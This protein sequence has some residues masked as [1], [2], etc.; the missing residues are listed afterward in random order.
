M[1]SYV[2]GFMFDGSG[3]VALVRKNKPEWQKGKLNG[4][5]G[6]IEQGEIPI[7]AMIRE[8]D[9]ETG[10]LHHGWQEICTLYGDGFAVHFFATLGN[11]TQ[12]KTMETEEIVTVP[13]HSVS[14]ETCIPNLTWLISYG[15][16][17]RL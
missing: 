11:L 1:Q 6:K 17:R 9:E 15:V 7:E 13:I 8:F 16:D 5:G 3:N 2:A 4:I 10:C 14:V 12:L